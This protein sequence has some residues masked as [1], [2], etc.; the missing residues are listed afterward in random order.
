M[1]A[2]DGSE[3]LKLEFGQAATIWRVN[4]GWTRRKDKGIFGFVLDT[5]RGYWAKD[6]AATPDDPD[7][8]LSDA[9]KRVVPF[10]EDRRNCLLVTPLV[11]LDAEQMATLPG[12][13]QALDPGRVPARGPGTRSR[14]ASDRRRSQR[15]LVLRSRRGRRR[16]PAQTDRRSGSDRAGGAPPP[17]SCATSPPTARTSSAP[18]TPARTARSPAT[19]ACSAM[20]TSATTASLTAL[21][22]A[23]YCWTLPARRLRP[24]T[25]RA[26]MTTQPSSSAAAT[27]PSSTASSTCSSPNA[28]GFPMNRRS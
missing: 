7:D 20:A 2:Q 5:E 1:S 13:A 3:L 10:V 11:A 6:D 15:A 14:T 18:S 8:P 26:A 19:T 28:A 24:R 17:W 21:R 22:S 16:G 27:R 25:P 23:T 12:G 4:L 9:N